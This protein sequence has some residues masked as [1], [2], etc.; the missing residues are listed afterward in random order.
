MKHQW[1]ALLLLGALLAGCVPQD[2]LP[3]TSVPS[4]VPTAPSTVPTEPTETLPEIIPATLLDQAEPVGDDDRLLYV[5]SSHVESMA[6]P[7]MQLFGNALLLYE[8]QPGADPGAMAL[9]LIRLEDGALLAETKL[10]AGGGCGVKA[11]NGTIMLYDSDLG[12]VTILDGRLSVI[13][14]YDLPYAGN[15]WYPDPSLQRMYI[16]VADRGL[17]A[18]D[19][20]TGAE[21]WIISQGAAF[22]VKSADATYLI[23]EYTDKIDLRTYTMCLDLATGSLESVPCSGSVGAVYRSGDTWLICPRGFAGDYTVVQQQSTGTFRWTEAIARMLTHRGHLLLPREHYRAFWLYNADGSFV[24]RCDLTDMPYA[25]A[26]SDF[27]WSDVWNG[28]FF[29]DTWDNA[30]HLMFWDIR[31]GQDGAPLEITPLGSQ[32]PPAHT[33]D[34]VYYQ[35]AQA[36]SQRFGVDIRIAEQCMLDYGIYESIELRDDY[37]VSVAL[38]ALERCLSRYPEGMLAQLSFGSNAQLRIEL[39]GALRAKDHTTS[40]PELANGFVSKLADGYIL[41]L[42]AFDLSDSTIYHELSHV[43]DKRLEWY[44]TIYPDAA[45][46]EDAWLTLQPEGFR[47]AYSYTDIPADILAYSD[48][49][50]FIRDYAMTYPAEDRAT[51]M[52]AAMTQDDRFENSAAMQEK[53]RFYAQ[54]IRAAF[55]TAGWPETAAWERP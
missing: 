51:L 5:P 25:T 39:V 28:Y 3:S 13:K 20:E 46:N 41:V 22:S 34:P 11:G 50:Y 2:T 21:R 16:F 45:F 53:M 35:Q 4:S 48:S 19:L 9:Q 36:L 31:K 1:I 12:Q 32:S 49:G 8:Y 52:A 29:I 42:D 47:F 40:H 15:L 43:I 37:S 44:A 33:V 18:L 30:A 27:V 24:S 14:T 17:L 23:F 6:L 26:G 54:C 55:Q 7:Q 38:A 10:S